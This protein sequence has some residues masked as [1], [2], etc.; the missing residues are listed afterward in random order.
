MDTFTWIDRDWH[1][2]TLARLTGG[3]IV[4]TQ[5]HVIDLTSPE[6]EA[7]GVAWWE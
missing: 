5:F 2:Q 6:S 7:K 3:V 1:M 4:A